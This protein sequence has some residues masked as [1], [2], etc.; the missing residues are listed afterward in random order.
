MTTER[1]STLYT[2]NKDQNCQFKFPEGGWCC[3]CVGLYDSRGIMCD[4]P[5]PHWDRTGEYMIQLMKEGARDTSDAYFNIYCDKTWMNR[6]V[7][8]LQH[9]QFKSVEALERA[10]TTEGKK[11]GTYEKRYNIVKGSVTLREEAAA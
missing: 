4:D 2:S 1:W 5:R 7:Y 6:I 8:N 3:Y 9:G 10:A 11:R